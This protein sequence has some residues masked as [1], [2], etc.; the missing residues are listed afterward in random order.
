MPYTGKDTDRIGLLDP[1]IVGRASD[2][3]ELGESR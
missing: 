2:L 1:L 3:Y